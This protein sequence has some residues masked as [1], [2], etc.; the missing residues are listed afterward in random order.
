MFLRNF[1]GILDNQWMPFI[2]VKQEKIQ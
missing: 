2:G 1:S